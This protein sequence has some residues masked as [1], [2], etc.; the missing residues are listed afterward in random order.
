LLHLDGVENLGLAG[1]GHGRTRARADKTEEAPPPEKRP[2]HVRRARP[3]IRHPARF[4]AI[5]DSAALAS[6]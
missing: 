1:H 5:H 4:D 2:L 6:P 3:S